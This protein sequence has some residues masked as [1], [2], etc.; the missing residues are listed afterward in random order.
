MLGLVKRFLADGRIAAAEI[1]CLHQWGLRHRDA[2]GRWP[3]M[4]VFDRLTKAIADNVSEEERADLQGLFLSLVGGSV[5]VHL[6][7]EGAS[8][9]PLDVSPPAITCESSVFVFTGR[10]AYGTRAR[11]ASEVLSRG[12]KVEASVTNR[13]SYLVVGTFGSQDWLHTADG[14][15]IERAFELRNGGCQICIVGENHWADSLYAA[16]EESKRL[17]V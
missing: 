12:G 5:V 4:P 10:F 2:I 3:L 13:T 1:R 8:T 15:K 9:L 6:I 7:D 14:R 11:C 17:G 16:A